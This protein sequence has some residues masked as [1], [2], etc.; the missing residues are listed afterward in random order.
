MS[1][2]TQ[3]KFFDESLRIQKEISNKIDIIEKTSRYSEWQRI[4]HSKEYK[5]KI[6]KFGFRLY[7]QH[8]QDGILEYLLNSMHICG[9]IFLEFGCETGI[10]NNTRYLLLKNFSGKWIDSNAEYIR[11]I[12][13]LYKNLIDEK[14]LETECLKINSTNINNVVRDN[15]DVLVIDTDWNDYWIF[16][17]L[18]KLPKIIV[19]E[20]NSFLGKEASV[21]VPENNE[22][23]WT[24]TN[25]FG[26]SWRALLNLGLDK[27]YTLVSCSI[28]GSDMFFVRND[29][30]KYLEFSKYFNSEELYESPKY[31]LC[32]NLGHPL[33]VEKMPIESWIYV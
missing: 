3:E 33:M 19:I 11:F 24:G 25:Y 14:R 1:D 2:I 8:D 26:S 21:T 30:I 18:E 20:Y 16:N 31:N 13:D 6:N 10:E 15:L 28:A 27:G 17:A 22:F 7:S 5:N 32:F 29:L 12:G 4:I 23:V 9:G